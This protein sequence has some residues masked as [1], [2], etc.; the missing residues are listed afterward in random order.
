[1][2]PGLVGILWLG[3]AF[4]ET[5]RVYATP[6][7]QSLYLRTC[8]ISAC[9]FSWSQIHRYDVKKEML[10]YPIWRVRRTSSDLRLGQLVCLVQAHIPDAVRQHSSFEHVY[11]AFVNVIRK[12]QMTVPESLKQHRML[13]NKNSGKHRRVW[14]TLN[15]VQGFLRF[16]FESSYST[17]KH[18]TKHHTTHDSACLYMKMCLVAH[19]RLSDLDVRADFPRQNV[20]CIGFTGTTLKA[21]YSPIKRKDSSAV[22]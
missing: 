3:V 7:W 8:E 16:F 13:Y 9:H 22:Q 10:K 6:H 5:R 15:N 18:H 19:A 4:V 20:T 14:I 17:R 2:A 21:Q 12:Q 11:T 1:M